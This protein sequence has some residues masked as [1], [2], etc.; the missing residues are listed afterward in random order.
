MM[1]AAR[2]RGT[3]GLSTPRDAPPVGDPCRGQHRTAR[4]PYSQPHR[5]PAPR[6][7]RYG[8]GTPSPF[9]RAT[10]RSEWSRPQGYG[11]C[12]RSSTL[13][14]ASGGHGAQPHRWPWRRGRPCSF[15]VA[16]DGPRASAAGWSAV[17]N[18]QTREER[19][20]TNVAAGTGQISSRNNIWFLAVGFHLLK[21]RLT[22]QS[23]IHYY[24]LF[25]KKYYYYY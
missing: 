15:V 23:H 8:A 12:R 4:A 18:R 11:W 20:R 21:F 3:P 25:K 17:Q 14:P 24:Y 6:R 9:A 1:V 13:R 19:V 7:T 10:N 2:A 16:T 22:D 5:S